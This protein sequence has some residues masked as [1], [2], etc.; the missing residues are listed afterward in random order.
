MCC[1]YCFPSVS[2][3]TVSLIHP[4]W[5]YVFLTWH[6]MCVQFNLQL[7]WSEIYWIFSEFVNA[8]INFTAANTLKQL[9]HRTTMKRRL[10]FD[11]F[12]FCQ[13]WWVHAWFW[14]CSLIRK[15]M[16]KTFVSVLHLFISEDCYMSL[17]CTPY[18]VSG[19]WILCVSF[20]LSWWIIKESYLRMIQTSN[21]QRR[22]LVTFTVW[23]SSTASSQRTMV[24]SCQR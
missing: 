15:K 5:S 14:F 3:S 23:E 2:E 16:T 18:K 9:N 19:E 10:E 20:Q 7:V 21:V 24:V 6:V 22:L 11:T 12:A 4:F 1:C 17:Q 8:T 13:F